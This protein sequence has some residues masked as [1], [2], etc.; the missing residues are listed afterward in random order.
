MKHH[1][2]EVTYRQGKAQAAYLYIARRPGDISART[3]V[4]QTGYVID[5][6]PD[7]RAIGIEI[8]SPATATI[9]SVNDALRLANHP[10]ILAEDLKPLRA[11]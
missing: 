4:T 8:P 1:Y 7:G 9:Q 6:A 11:A 5:F 2:L 3:L 10:P